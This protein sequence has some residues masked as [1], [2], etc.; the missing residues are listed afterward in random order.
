[1]TTST[2]VLTRLTLGLAGAALAATALSACGSSSSASGDSSMA[3]MSGMSGM[4]AT[5][6]A[7]M[8]SMPMSSSAA[9]GDMAGMAMVT[10]KHFAYT[11]TT[12]V[13][14]GTSVM[15]QNDDSVAHTLTSNKGGKGISFTVTV[16]AGGTATFKAPTTP[17]RYAYHCDYHAEMH[18]TLTVS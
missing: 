13:A 4:S 18:G 3:G 7:P 14:P 11:G 10:I 1:M 2:H 16:A 15:V 6:S 12:T 8:S 17:G 5:S 9:G